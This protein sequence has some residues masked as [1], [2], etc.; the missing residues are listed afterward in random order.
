MTAPEPTAEHAD[1][2]AV[3][4]AL[5]E[6]V[7]PGTDVWH[8]NAAR[9]VLTSTDPA[10]HSAMLDALVRAGV[11]PD[12][13]ALR[14]HLAIAEA[15]ASHLAA[16]IR[17]ARESLARNRGRGVGWEKVSQALRPVGLPD[18]LARA[19]R[20]GRMHTVSAQPNPRFGQ[21]AP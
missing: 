12:V 14:H 11:L 13:D 19:E 4:L 6:G 20:R 17:D 9:R 18:A 3:V 7:T 16:T 15:D 1:A 10:V 21:V 5:A 2:V 8:N